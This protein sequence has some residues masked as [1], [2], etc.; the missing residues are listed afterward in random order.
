MFACMNCNHIDNRPGIIFCPRC[1]SQLF[2][3]LPPVTQSTA[4][5]PPISPVMSVNTQSLV[6]EGPEQSRA[7]TPHSMYRELYQ[8]H[9]TLM[10]GDPFWKR[11][12]KHLAAYQTREQ[13]TESLDDLAKL[14]RETLIRARQ[15]IVDAEFAR[16]QAEYEDAILREQLT[17]RANMMAD[18][19][20]QLSQLF[21][22]D[23]YANVPDEIKADIINSLFRQAEEMI[24]TANNPIIDGHVLPRS[25]NNNDDV[26]LIDADEF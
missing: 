18:Y 2:N 19:L 5:S 10:Q 11:L 17:R 6:R 26:I 24:F 20:D 21:S 8:A 9:E 25:L 1:G 4:D 14:Q 23:R 15:Q 12:G 3:L 22:A 13:A 16:R 7:I